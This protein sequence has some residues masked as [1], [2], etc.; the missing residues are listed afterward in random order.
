MRHT[1]NLRKKARGRPQ[2]GQRLY[3]LVENFDFLCALAII[4]FFAKVYSS[5]S[6]RETAPRY[7]HACPTL[8]GGDG[9]T[10]S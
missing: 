3:D 9:T 1:P 5:C 8:R 2:R 6:A 4:D 10:S 7:A